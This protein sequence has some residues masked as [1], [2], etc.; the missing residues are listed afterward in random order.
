MSV[1]RIAATAVYFIVCAVIIYLI[2]LGKGEG[3]DLSG[4]IVARNNDTYFSTHG[5]KHT[6]EALRERATI[7]CMLIFIAISV[8][9]N[10][11]WGL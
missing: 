2:Y 7:I 5:K 11:S 8:V 1:I 6:Q 10:M 4:T 9:L 3:A